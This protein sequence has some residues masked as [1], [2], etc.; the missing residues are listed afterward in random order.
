MGI[1]QGGVNGLAPGPHTHGVA[2]LDGITST[3]SGD[4][5]AASERTDISGNKTDLIN[6]S[7]QTSILAFLADP[8]GAPTVGDRYIILTPATGAWT[9]QEDKITEWNGTSWD[10]ITPVCG[11]TVFDEGGGCYE[12]FNGGDW[13]KFEKLLAHAQLPDTGTN[14]HAQ[15]D[16]HVDGDGSD[17][18][19]VA[20]NTTDR[21]THANKTELDLLTDGDHDVRIDNPHSV[22]K[23]QIGSAD[24]I[25]FDFINLGNI[26][27]GTKVDAGRAVPF[28]CSIIKVVGHR[29]DAGGSG[30]STIIDINKNGATVYTTQGNRLTFLQSAGSDLSVLAIDPDV[31]DLAAGDTITMD[32]DQT[33][34]GASPKELSVTVYATID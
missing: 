17:H 4:I 5:I 18:A 2:D 12:H 29:V 34:T 27:T 23:A 6:L 22:T 20:V 26:S 10:F 1:E 14:T 19:D 8:P 3:G 7:F 31:V 15:I 28:A 25:Q 9:G 24:T 16:T 13:I 33:E 11:T 32:V 21:H 30:G